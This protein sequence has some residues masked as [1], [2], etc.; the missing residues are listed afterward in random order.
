MSKE[1]R[2]P[3]ADDIA[4]FLA[5]KRALGHSY[6]RGEFTLR[7][8]DRFAA[9]QRGRSAPL[10]RLPEIIRAWLSRKVDRQPITLAAEHVVIRQ[11][12]LFRRRRDAEAFV[13]PRTWAPASTKSQF[14][15]TILS[16]QDVVRVI[17][18]ARALK[19]PAFRATLYRAFLLVLYLLTRPLSDRS[20]PRNA[21]AW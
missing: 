11:F 3:F 18:G 19:P 20:E 6:Q 21:H 4:A 5:F 13:P 8:F 15:P 10:R 7:A 12:C 9:K 1:F 17:R 14:L 16:K 2:G